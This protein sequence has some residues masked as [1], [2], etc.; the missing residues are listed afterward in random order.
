[1]KLYSRKSAMAV[2]YYLMAID[3]KVSTDELE[4]YN[5]IGAEIDPESFSDYR[6]ELI[7][8]CETYIQVDDDDE[9]YDIVLE[10]VD[11]ALQ[12]KEQEDQ[13]IPSRLLVWN[14][15]VIAF[16]N[17]EYDNAERRLI[18]HVVRLTEMDDSV[19]LQMEELLKSSVAVEKELTWI[20]TSNRPYS[21]VAP[22]VEELDRRL[23][24][25]L[26]SAK[27]LIDDELSEPSTQAI[28]VKA[29]VIDK[30]KEEIVN[31]SKMIVKDVKNTF[32]EI[33][34]PIS[35]GFKKGKSRLLGS[36]GRS[37]HGLE[38]TQT[39]PANRTSEKGDE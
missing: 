16:S 11:K 3:E 20:K 34:G 24:N 26:Q 33:A 29:D 12:G 17:R 39:D 25:I 8:K 2:F 21:E 9:Y 37:N 38:S 5:E 4:K 18:K 31:D 1:M 35:A 14:M 32:R 28:E 36:L 15:L 22:I 27:D 30:V 13:T 6:D 7:K 10:G 19:F 23:A